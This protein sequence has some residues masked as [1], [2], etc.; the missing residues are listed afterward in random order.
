M[1]FAS[2]L[3]FNC[4]ILRATFSLRVSFLPVS[5]VISRGVSVNIKASEL[6]GTVMALSV[7]SL[8]F[9]VIS[10]TGNETGLADTNR[11]HKIK[12]EI[13]RLL[14]AVVLNGNGYTIL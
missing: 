12:K 8:L 3:I 9:M 13:N 6:P 4:T 1:D 11:E 10:A 14:I 7:T 5:L 2:L